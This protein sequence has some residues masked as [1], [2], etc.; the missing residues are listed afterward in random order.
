MGTKRCYSCQSVKLLSA[1]SKNKG[2]PDG[3]NPQ[4]QECFRAYYAAW[5]LKN[6]EKVRESQRR[7][8]AENAE[9]QK[10]KTAAWKKANPERAKEND[11][12]LRLENTDR[13]RTNNAAWRKANRDRLREQGRKDREAR[14]EYYKAKGREYRQKNK[15]AVLADR[16]LRKARKRNATPIWLTKEHKIEM[17]AFYECAALLNTFDG[18]QYHVDHII[19]ISGADVCGLHV[20]WNLQILSAK[21]NLQK[22]TVY[23]K[24]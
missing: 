1:F 7:Y 6:V 5:R 10:A 21:E 14:P 2:K 23:R 18:Q 15:G 20:P 19:P 11:R 24:S 12:R 4:C 8:C 3:V 13:Y 17:R 9:R 22:G 16:A